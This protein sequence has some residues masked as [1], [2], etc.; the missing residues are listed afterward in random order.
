MVPSSSRQLLV[1]SL[2]TLAFLLS[3]L[4]YHRKRGISAQ[5]DPGG[6]TQDTDSNP[7]DPK[8]QTEDLQVSS[9]A[10]L[11]AEKQLVDTE[12]LREIVTSA[13]GGI[14]IKTDKPQSPFR[15][16]EEEKAKPECSTQQSPELLTEKDLS[17]TC[18]GIHTLAAGEELGINE[19]DTE[20]EMNATECPLS[21]L[22]QEIYLQKIP[23]NLVVKED[24]KIVL[25]E[26]SFYNSLECT[27]HLTDQISDT[28]SLP[29]RVVEEKEVLETADKLDTSV[30][31]TISLQEPSKSCSLFPEVCVVAISDSVER[32]A[33]TQS[34]IAGGLDA[35]PLDKVTME[36]ISIKLQESDIR[37]R[38]DYGGTGEEFQ[39]NKSEVQVLPLNIIVT[40]SSKFV[41]SVENDVV[42]IPSISD[43]KISSSTEDTEETEKSESVSGIDSFSVAT[44]VI[45]CKAS[46]ETLAVEKHVPADED[47]EKSVAWDATEGSASVLLECNLSSVELKENVMRET[48]S[49]TDSVSGNGGKAKSFGAVSEQQTTERD[50][51]NHSPVDVMLA[52]PSISSC[53]DAQSEGSSDSGKG[54]SD[55]ATPPLRTPASGSSL[56]GD[57]S[58]P[59]VYEFVVPQYLV[60][61][62]IGR[63]GCFVHEI[64]KNTNASI[65]IKRHPD[66]RKLK[67]CAVEGTHTDIESALEMIREKFPE[68]RYPDVTLE[69]VC[70]VPP[71]PTFPLIPES[72]QLRLVEGVTNDVIL[73]SLISPSHFFLQQPTHPSFLAL[74]QLNACMNI[75]YSEPLAPPLPTP[76]QVSSICVAPAVG[77]WYRAQVVVVDEETDACEIGR[78]HV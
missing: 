33:Q 41:E 13:H 39:G 78:A 56:S 52:S 61:R 42:S 65:F 4:W 25:L 19:C 54:C 3:L 53:S 63:H 1:W 5:S 35:L 74:S 38:Q 22:D 72:L 34:S 26:G 55:V 45:T 73:S 60:G 7:K 64:K 70:F 68:N 57:A 76:I 62:L 8:Q 2:P 23:V 28:D 30:G 9:T 77:G 17:E 31:I 36:D 6:T 46:A 67:I 18:S 43:T 27:E 14:K 71:V 12:Q 47:V 59:S 69:Q 51:A 48:S 32:T 40:Q 37:I 21:N 11:L 24:P 29:A 16:A 15:S 44:A 49:D 20:K 75:C 50:S 10:F 58:V 66:T